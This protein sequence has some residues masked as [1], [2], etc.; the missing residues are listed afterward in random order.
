[1]KALHSLSS[2]PDN[3]RFIIEELCFGDN[4]P[5]SFSC[6]AGECLGVSGESGVGKTLLLRSLADLD[7]HDGIIMLDGRQCS[8]YQGPEWRRLVALVPAE[9]RWWYPEVGLHLPPG[10]NKSQVSALVV[11]CGFGIDVLDWQVSRL[12]TGEKQRLAVVR[13]LIR[14]PAVLLLDETGI[15]LDPRNSFLLE[16]VIEDYRIVHQAPVIWVSHDK[17]QLARV[18]QQ[19]MTMHRNQLDFSLS[20]SAGKQQL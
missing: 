16:K 15:G 19:Q 5:Y 11:S 4:G 17:E 12:S 18:S 14:E 8:T 1:M 3:P 13:A 9:S 7:R 20:K 6:P 2:S 10:Y